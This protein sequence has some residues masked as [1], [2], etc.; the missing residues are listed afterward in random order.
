MNEETKALMTHASGRRSF[1][2]FACAACN[3]PSSP[4]RTSHTGDH[5]VGAEH[6][7]GREAGPWVAPSRGP[8]GEFWRGS[9]LPLLSNFRW[10]Y[11]EKSCRQSG[12]GRTAR[13]ALVRWPDLGRASFC[14][15]VFV[16]PIH[17]HFPPAFRDFPCHI[18]LGARGYPSP[19]PPLRK[20]I[21][22]RAFLPSLAG[23]H[24]LSGVF[25]LVMCSVVQQPDQLLSILTDLCVSVCMCV[26]AH[27]HSHTYWPHQDKP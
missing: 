10:K 4:T 23:I 18:H 21:P 14:E 25:Q 2:W 20:L 11:N 26:C 24:S 8:Q 5:A 1:L 9:H 3:P 6:V 15:P 22:C 17:F 19:S 13:R 16:P 12:V 27:A 7:G